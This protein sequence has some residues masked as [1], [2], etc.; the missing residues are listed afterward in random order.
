MPLFIV[1]VCFITF[2]RDGY[3]DWLLPGFGLFLTVPNRITVLS[4]T[5]RN[6]LHP[7]VINYAWIW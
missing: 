7:A 1:T 2:L 3:N 4:D 6:V 5:E